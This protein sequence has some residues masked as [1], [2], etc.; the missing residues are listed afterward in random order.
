MDEAYVLSDDRSRVDGEVVYSYLSRDSY[1][2]KGRSRE[3]VKE[4]IENSY[5]VAI[6][7]PVAGMVAFARV[8]T[9]WATM[10]Y[11]CDLFVLGPH[12]GRGLGKRLVE[13][14][15]THPRL[16]SLSGFLMTADAHGLYEQ[17]GFVQSDEVCRKFMR[18]PRSSY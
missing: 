18:K 13:Q 1:W 15:C 3:V 10:Y 7:H 4:S 6:H 14:I 5:C 17:F 2:A 9:D 16:A 8:V 11:V 12:R